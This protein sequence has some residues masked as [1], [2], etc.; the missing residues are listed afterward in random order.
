MCTSADTVLT[1]TSMTTVSVSIRSAQSACRLPDSMKRSTV[2]VKISVSLKPT[3]KKAHHDSNA[4][5]TRKPDVMYSDAF[6][7]SDVPNR[8]TIR[9]PSSGR[10]TMAWYM[11][12]PSTLHHV[13]VF[14]R[15]RAAVAEEHHQYG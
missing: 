14:D 15:D 13:H 10:K 8:P 2:V 4:Q 11:I 1:T 6:A 9:K 5:I 7:P 3:L 12:L